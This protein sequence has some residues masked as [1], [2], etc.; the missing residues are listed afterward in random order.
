[1]QFIF[2][3]FNAECVKEV[4]SLMWVYVLIGN[5]IRG[6]GETPIMPLGISYIED[7]AKSESSPLYIGKFE[8]LLYSF[9]G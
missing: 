2:C 3:C 9:A 4:K 7:F 5:I 1:M 6:M 8:S